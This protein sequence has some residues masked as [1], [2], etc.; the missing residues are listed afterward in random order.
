MTLKTW[1]KTVTVMAVCMALA[2]SYPLISSCASLQ[3]KNSVVTISNTEFRTLV[4]DD[5]EIKVPIDWPDI[6]DEKK[7][8]A[9]YAPLKDQLIACV[10]SHIGD[11]PPYKES[12]I[13]VFLGPCRQT[14]GGSHYIADPETNDYWFYNDMVG[15]DI[16]GLF[17]FMN[18]E[19]YLELLF[20]FVWT[21]D[22]V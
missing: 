20:G 2:L 7:F 16:L 22:E 19:S 9:N 6:M 11:E 4:L 5:L 13:L 12:Y 14:I 3:I 18:K 10:F 8:K 17:N 1:K 21:C 15:Q